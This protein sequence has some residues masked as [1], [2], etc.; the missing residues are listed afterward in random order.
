VDRKTF[1]PVFDSDMCTGCAVCAS[2]CPRG[3]IREA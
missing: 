1:R 3:A 2:S